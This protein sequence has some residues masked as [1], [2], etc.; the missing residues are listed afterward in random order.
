M[1]NFDRFRARE[2]EPPKFLTDNRGVSFDPPPS[3]SGDHALLQ[4]IPTSRGQVTATARIVKDLAHI[5]RVNAGDI[6]IANSTDPGWTPVFAVISGVIVE[7][8]GMLSHSSCLAREYGFPAVQL[9]G[10]LSSIPDGATIELDGNTGRVR[11]TE[12][13]PIPA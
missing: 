3:D 13:S 1:R 12:P 10:A 4:G 8:G 2:W 6:L 9:E 5:E 7:T 11:I